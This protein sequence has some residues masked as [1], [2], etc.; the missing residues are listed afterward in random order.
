MIVHIRIDVDVLDL[1][2]GVVRLALDPDVRARAEVLLDSA[3]E[4]ALSVVART[5]VVPAN[6]G[7]LKLSLSLKQCLRSK[8]TLFCY[9]KDALIAD[10]ITGQLELQTVGS[11][12]GCGEVEPILHVG[13]DLEDIPVRKQK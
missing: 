13:D 12:A 4:L 1:V 9:L 3:P 5:P 2:D 10:D 6:V 11:D 8:I 7:P